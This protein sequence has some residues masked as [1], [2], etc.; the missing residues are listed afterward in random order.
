M[1]RDNGDDENQVV[2]D[3]TEIIFPCS[4]TS[5]QQVE[6]QNNMKYTL[7]NDGPFPFILTTGITY[8]TRLHLHSTKIQT[9]EY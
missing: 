5:Q 7:N 3:G 8:S 9:L 4:S 2:Q 1:A 6:P